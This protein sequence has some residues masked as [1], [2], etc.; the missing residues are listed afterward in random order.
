MTRAFRSPIAMACLLAAGCYTRLATVGPP[1][2]TGGGG[3]GVIADSGAAPPETVT[4]KDREV[5]YW[6]RDFFGRPRLRCYESYYNDD[7]HHFHDYPWWYR[8]RSY[9]RDYDC[10]CPYHI[11][12]H[13]TC[14]LCW[15]YCDRYARYECRTCPSPG[16]PERDEPPASSGPSAT[17]PQG[18]GPARG[19]G[20]RSVMPGKPRPFAGP[21]PSVGTKPSDRQLR[22]ESGEKS[23][24]VDSTDRAESG[25]GTA[26]DK[27]AETAPQDTT[28]PQ[29][30]PVRPPR[31]IHGRR[32]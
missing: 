13:P 10:H 1:P 4:I 7:W 11:S 8:G 21:R 17:P 28:R 16:T 26:E 31:R 5:C 19:G 30:P 14:R 25:K 18:V 2:G 22:K 6:E 23:T 27:S 3:E 9:Y 29:S 20:S 15:R 32:R 24:P 12:Y